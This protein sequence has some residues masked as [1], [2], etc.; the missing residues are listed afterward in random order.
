MSTSRLTGHLRSHKVVVLPGPLSGHCR[1]QLT[2]LLTKY[3]E[4]TPALTKLPQQTLTLD[5]ISSTGH[6]LGSILSSC[7]CIPR[8]GAM[9]CPTWLGPWPNI[10]NICQSSHN[11][12]QVANNFLTRP[13]DYAWIFPTG[14][15]VSQIVSD[16][17]RNSMN[18]LQ[19][20]PGLSNLAPRPP[21]SVVGPTTRLSE[22]LHHFYGQLNVFGLLVP[23]WLALSF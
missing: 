13:R 16:W 11:I 18:Y 23:A 8:S 1:P 10:S 15:I 6:S 7:R 22:T 14:T 20:S 3:P 19:P 5:Q 12:H 4:P 17:H 21:K 9:I 2:L